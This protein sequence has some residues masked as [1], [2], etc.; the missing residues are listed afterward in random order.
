M[1]KYRGI[2]ITSS[3]IFILLSC[4]IP[5]SEGQTFLPLDKIF[6]EPLSNRWN[7]NYQHP[8]INPLYVNFQNNEV[9]NYKLFCSGSDQFIFNTEMFYIHEKGRVFSKWNPYI[10][11]SQRPPPLFCNQLHI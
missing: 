5:Q 9:G 4:F 10:V 8:L 1:K 11:I 2:V 7:T 6:G 3:T